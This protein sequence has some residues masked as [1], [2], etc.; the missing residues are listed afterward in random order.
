[1]TI[2]IRILQILVENLNYLVLFYF[3]ALN[4]FYLI[5]TIFAFF[6]L[7]VYARRLKA[8]NVEELITTAGAPPIT[9]L[10]PAYNE[11]ATCV[12]S[13][14][15]LLALNYPEY[16]IIV[17][18]D[19]SADNTMSRLTEAFDLQPAA[20]V[21][22]AEIPSATIKG[23]Y[24][25]QHQP[26]LWA[27]DKANGG[28]ADAL[29]AGLKFCRTPLFCAMDADSI[30]E[31]DALIRIVRPFLE[32]ARTIAA[33]GI[34]R[35]VNDCTIKAGTLMEIRL[36][37]NIWAKFQVLEYLRA[38]LSG[39]MG[40]S[41]LDATLIISGAFGMFK[42]PAVVEVGGYAT[43]TVGEDMELVVRLHRR[44]REQRIPYK[45][46]FVPDPV[47][48]TEC[49][50]STKILGRQRDRWQRGL[51]EVLTRHRIMF[52]NPRYGRIGLLAYPYFYLLEM[53]GPAIEMPGYVAFLVAL[54]MGTVS[55]PFIIA[56]FMA[57]FI[58]GVALSVFSVA[59]EEL[60]FR[61]YPRTIDLLKLFMLA[62]VE[63]FGY[64]QLTIYWR[65]HG[66][67]SALR[68][69]QGWGKMERKGFKTETST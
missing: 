50:E 42:R 34:I 32:D 25:S 21:P 7:R 47:A 33:G 53:L 11:E 36:P 62:V 52:L 16:E 40:W 1:M 66:F 29:N 15:A 13:V 65:M 44:F 64:R 18:N 19:G 41:A 27:I 8:I 28:K 37:R 46:S 60:T 3:L 67:I 23:L 24:R 31:R 38:F 10:A 22:M 4:L 9:L 35:I 43:D 17:I 2:I 12:E 26:N 48:W 57:A 61:R 39:R 20:R 56:F 5:T 63:N 51:F 54:I 69:V 55:V 59:L 45:I 30:L 6:A 58:F 49:P 14:R 68:K